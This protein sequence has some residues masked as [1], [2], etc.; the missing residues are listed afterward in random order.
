[1]GVMGF[2]HAV[3]GGASLFPYLLVYFSQTNCEF[4]FL[5]P[6][7]CSSKGGGMAVGSVT[8]SPG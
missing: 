1:M 4:L 8:K 2:F 7:F 5:R 6:Y 3:G